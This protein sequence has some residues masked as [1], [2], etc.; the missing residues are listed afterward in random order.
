MVI[1]YYNSFMQY[2]AI[3]FFK[4][5][6]HRITENIVISVFFYVK[7]T[8]NGCYISKKQKTH[9]KCIGCEMNA[10]IKIFLL[11]ALGIYYLKR[12]ATD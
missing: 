5:Y 8:N 12:S 11:A 9:P 7:I 1:Q 3:D 6:I 10:D 4:I 2:F